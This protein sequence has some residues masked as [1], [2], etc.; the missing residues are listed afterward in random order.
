MRG[1]IRSNYPDFTEAVS[2]DYFLPGATANTKLIEWIYGA[3]PGNYKSFAWGVN[4]ACADFYRTYAPLF[5]EDSPF[6]GKYGREYTGSLKDASSGAK[7]LRS[8]TRANTYAETAPFIEFSYLLERNF[9][10][11]ADRILTRTAD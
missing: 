7:R 2:L 4:D 9:Q 8:Q 11:G 6:Q 1:A 3:N 5:S 10:I